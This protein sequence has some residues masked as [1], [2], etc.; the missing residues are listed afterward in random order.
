MPG[1]KPA[2]SLWAQGRE[3]MPR[4][5]RYA[6]VYDGIK[7]EA[8]TG[9]LGVLRAQSI[10]RGIQPQAFHSTLLTF[11]HSASQALS[12]RYYQSSPPNHHLPSPTNASAF[13]PALLCL[14]VHQANRPQTSPAQHKRVL[15]PRE[16]L[17]ARSKSA[18]RR[19]ALLNTRP[20]RLLELAGALVLGSPRHG[21]RHY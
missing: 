5:S 18:L 15:S 3:T 11:W 16:P 20:V 8:N 12:S 7:E 4:A 10:R 19:E 17:R 6:R 1:K 21:D 2:S 14:S 13:P 9:Y